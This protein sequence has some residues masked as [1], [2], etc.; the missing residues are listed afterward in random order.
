ALINSIMKFNGADW[1]PAADENTQY[2]AGSGLNLNRTTFSIPDG[3]L[4]GAHLQDSTVSGIDIAAGAIASSH[5]Q[6][7]AITTS[8]IADNS[9]TSSDVQNGSLTGADIA[10][11]AIASSHIQAGAVT[12]SEIADNSITGADVQNGSLTGTDI[13]TASITG[14]DIAAASIP[15]GDLDF[16]PGDISGITA[17]AGLIGGGV[18]GDIGISLA[19]T[20]AQSE[21]FQNTVVFDSTV[22]FGQILKVDGDRLLLGS[23]RA[24]LPRDQLLAMSKSFNQDVTVTFGIRTE[25][26]VNQGTGGI[27]GIDMSVGDMA[28]HGSGNATAISAE[29]LAPAASKAN[30]I[31]VFAR[32]G[33][34]STAMENLMESGR[35]LTLEL[36]P[37]LTAYT[38]L[39]L[40]AGQISQAGLRE[41]L[42]SRAH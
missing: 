22:E 1:I 8:E 9:V 26:L 5:I 37:R 3:A 36:D 25:A 41:T 27:I 10:G 28:S 13:L 7:G 12:A 23:V 33:V 4:T 35:G 29:A 21:T 11:A 38:A 2:D 30:R 14:S 40:E 39:P 20:I 31:A 17:G 19:A 42:K 16:V 18:S 32:E 15:I 24:S 6:A 34:F